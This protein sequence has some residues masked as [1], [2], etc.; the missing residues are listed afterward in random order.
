MKNRPAPAAARPTSF[1][2]WHRYA[3][4][5]R[6][7]KRN[8]ARKRA[9]TTRSAGPDLS[10]D[11]LVEHLKATRRYCRLDDLFCDEDGRCPGCG[12]TGQWSR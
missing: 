4:T 7:G 11:A 8:S 12:N 1:L 5:A 3:A 9:R 2:P 10:G 6:A